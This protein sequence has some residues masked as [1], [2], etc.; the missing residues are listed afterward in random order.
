MT[1]GEKNIALNIDKEVG[2]SQDIPVSG[3]PL[4]LAPTDGESTSSIPRG[5]VIVLIMLGV[6]LVIGIF[7]LIKQLRGSDNR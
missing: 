4:L 5:T 1:V 7:I 6:F 2:V 3:T